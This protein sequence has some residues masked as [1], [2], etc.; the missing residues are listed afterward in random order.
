MT[1]LNSQQKQLLFDYSLG[2]T[3]EHENAEARRL[4]AFSQEASEVYRAV[5]LALSPLD[6]LEPEVCPD[7][8]VDRTISRLQEEAQLASGRD[9][10]EEL[11]TGAAADATIVRVPFWRN[12]GDI[13]A[14]AAVVVL[15]VGV[16]L[17]TLGFARQK[18][19]QTRCQS[20]LAGIYT[21]LADYVSDHEGQMPSVAM[22]PGAPWWK[23]GYQGVENH[24]NTRRAWPLVQQRYVPLKR[25]VCA[26]RRESRNLRFDTVKI[27]NYNDFPGRA[28]IHFSVRLGCPQ[29]PELGLTQRKVI[30]ADL[31]PISERLPATYSEPFRLRMGSDLMTSNSANH[32]RRGQNVLYC[33]GSV[34]FLRERHTSLSDDD[35]YTLAE[36][37]DGCEVT[38]CEVPSCDTDAFLVP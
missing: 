22:A 2:L 12:W 9:R 19:F 23:V 7:D 24:S 26:G 16:L 36:M 32:N 17:P 27:E 1:P 3:S 10:L 4:L 6:S 11:L 31:N 5:R 34:E 33:D 20:Q 15:F 28:Y 35:F 21:G 13:A 18:Y 8:L 14:V 25:F 37:S 29:S 38:G 30:F